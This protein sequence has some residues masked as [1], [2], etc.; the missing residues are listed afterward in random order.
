MIGN[1]TNLISYT[2]SKDSYILYIPIFFWFC[3]NYGLSLPLIALELSDIK[4]NIEINNLKN[5]LNLS[6]NYY[7]SII[8]NIVQFKKEDIL[9]QNINNTITYIKFVYFDNSTNYLYYDKLDNNDLLFPTLSKDN[10]D[11]SIYNI[12]KQYKVTPSTNGYEYNHINLQTNFSW[13]NNISL[14]SSYL[15]CDYIYLDLEERIKYAKSN[16]EYLIEQVQFDNYKTLISNF[17]KVKISY[18]HPCK[19]LI[20]RA[21]MQFLSDLNYN[22]NY[23]LN[24]FNKTN[25]LNTLTITLNGQNRL[26][27]KTF[28]YFNLIQPFQHH[29]NRPPFG[30]GIYSFSLYPEEHQPSSTCNLSKID[31]IV[32]EFGINN[33]INYNNV[34]HIRI[35]ALSYNIF[36]ILDGLGGL[37]FVS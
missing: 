10:N 3:R 16:H 9:F 18:S 32:L 29:S 15:L 27:T 26:E 31:D 23:S 4:V 13:V 12:N 28:D 2:N 1:V 30:V 22:F 37:L 24:Y 25:I 6:P 11:Y 8:D 34:A 21:N 7:I 17:S 36:K 33:N 5:V 19:E 20:F 14:N 35:Y